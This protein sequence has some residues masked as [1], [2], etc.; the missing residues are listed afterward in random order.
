MKC[1]DLITSL[2]M[3][4]VTVTALASEPPTVLSAEEER[5]IAWVDAHAGELE[6]QLE[7]H[8]NINSGTMNPD[9]VREIGALLAAEFEAIGFDTEWI[10]LPASADRAGHL[11]ARHAGDT[12]PRILAIGHLDTVFEPGDAFDRYVKEGNIARGPGVVDMKAGNLV[13]LYALRAL[14][15]HDLLEGAQIVA[16]FTGDEE[17]PGEPLAVVRK[18]LVEAGQWADVAL[19]FEAGVHDTNAAGETTV[20]YATI[21]RRSSSDWYLEVTGKQAHSSGIF[22]ENIGAGAVFEA[23]RI[24]NAFYEEVR[25]EQYLTFNAGSILAGTDVSYDRAETRGE[26]FGKTNVVPSRAVVHGGIRTISNEQLERAREA[27]RRIV[28]DNHPGTTATIT[29]GDGYPAMAPT[30]GNRELQKMLSDINVALGRNP[31]PAL[32]PAR[33]G[34]ADIS[35]VAPYTNALAGI[36]PYGKGG[37]SPRELIELD[38]LP[39]ATRRATLLLYRLIHPPKLSTTVA[40][41]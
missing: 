17:N 2:L 16:A 4:G 23:S 10:D 11:F 15:D 24:L 9:G 31:M 30:D 8:V 33:R 34:A 6:A 26:A 36:G 28:A 20:E 1:T 13:M 12:G 27:M 38:S 21:T 5:L 18:D 3:L 37:H 14:Y 35:F 29:F 41:Q 19:G 7:A 39:L 40:S 32:N 22:S 25:G